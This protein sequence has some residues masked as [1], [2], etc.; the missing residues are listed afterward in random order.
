MNN[1]INQEIVN[2]RLEDI[3]NLWAL[4]LTY[5]TVIIKVAK[6][7]EQG[8]RNRTHSAIA[9]VIEFVGSRFWKSLD[10]L[11]PRFGAS[12]FVIG[13]LVSIQPLVSGGYNFTLTWLDG[14]ELAGFT[15]RWWHYY[16]LLVVSAIALINSDHP[17]VI[18]GVNLVVL[19]YGV[20]LSMAVVT[21]GLSV[22]GVTAI[23]YIVY[24]VVGSLIGV[25]FGYRLGNLEARQNRLIAL[26]EK[27]G[28][29]EQG[30]REVD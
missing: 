28:K 4:F 26:M 6:S 22:L 29:G 15:F 1:K 11:T 24:G 17:H 21:G 30:V 18:A 25:K 7:M 8:A 19:L 23:I 20:I 3:K 13:M 2:K 14:Q 10:H 12:I 16:A 9:D 5:A 27:T